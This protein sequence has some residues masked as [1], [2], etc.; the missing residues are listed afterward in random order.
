MSDYCNWDL[1]LLYDNFQFHVMWCDNMFI[2]LGYIATSANV[3]Y[4]QQSSTHR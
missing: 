2:W 3:A 4:E 1:K